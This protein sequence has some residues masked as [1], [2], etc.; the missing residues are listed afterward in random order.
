MSQ[1][2]TQLHSIPADLPVPTDD[3]A[4][5]HLSGMRLPDIELEATSGGALSLARVRSEI[6]VVY[7]YPRTGQPDVPI[8][9]GW[10]AIPGAR[11]CTPHNVAF[12]DQ[13]AQLTL[14]GAAVFGLS[15]QT[16]DYQQ[17]M[18]QRLALPYPV[19]SD[20]QF[21]LTD[22]L[23][24]PTFDFQGVRLLKRLSFVAVDGAIVHVEYPVFPPGADAGRI[25]NWLRDPRG[26]KRDA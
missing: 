12:R 2:P 21:R 5:D 20:A 14:L 23:R 9:A 7:C 6:V 19:L 18:A 22:A 26:A 17:E 13:H 15:T 4:A 10:D 16:T 24:L 11:G 8:P 1:G 3:G 25:V